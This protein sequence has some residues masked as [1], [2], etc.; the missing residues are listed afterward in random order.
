MLKN[1]F[2]FSMDHQEKLFQFQPIQKEKLIMMPKVMDLIF[3]ALQ[4][5][6]SVFMSFLLM[7]KTQFS[8]RFLEFKR[9][10][11]RN[12]FKLQYIRISEATD[13]N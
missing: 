8:K 13:N 4:G 1:A 12:E 11:V 10:E 2:L 7:K 9:K 5:Y 6:S 3:F